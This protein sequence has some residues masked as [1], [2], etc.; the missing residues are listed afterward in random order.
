ME[1]STNSCQPI[2]SVLQSGLSGFGHWKESKY[3][4]S[5]ILVNSDMNKLHVEQWGSISVQSLREQRARESTEEE[6]SVYFNLPCRSINCSTEEGEFETVSLMEIDGIIHLLNKPGELL[7][8]K[9]T[10]LEVTGRK[11]SRHQYPRLAVHQPGCESPRRHGAS[12]I[13]CSAGPPFHCQRAF[14]DAVK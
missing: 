3:V 14:K 12:R 10:S 4:S 8:T 9:K 13:T 7:A 6:S 5:S 2:K 1:D 11:P